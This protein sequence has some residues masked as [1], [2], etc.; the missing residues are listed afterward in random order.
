MEVTFRFDG[1][2]SFGFL[3]QFNFP[4]PHVHATMFLG[5]VDIDAFDSIIGLGGLWRLN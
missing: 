5:E 2:V 4:E 3:W 1:I